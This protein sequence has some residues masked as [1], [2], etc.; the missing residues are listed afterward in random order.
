MLHGSRLYCYHNISP[1]KWTNILYS[2]HFQVY[3]YVGLYPDYFVF[4]ALY[5]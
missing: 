4:S 1:N 3:T 5:L 2:I